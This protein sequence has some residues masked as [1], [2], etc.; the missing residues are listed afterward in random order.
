MSGRNEDYF[1]DSEEKLLYLIGYLLIAKG[2]VGFTKENALDSYNKRFKN[3]DNS[4]DNLLDKFI[5]KSII[6]KSD[7]NYFLTPAGE[8]QAIAFLVKYYD[9]SYSNILATADAS[10]AY[11]KISSEIQGQYLGQ[12]DMTDKNQLDKLFS[13]VNVAESDSILDFGCGLGYITEFLQKKTG[14][15]CV[16]LDIAS[17][18]L[19]LAR[20]RNIGNDKLEYIHGDMNNPDFPPSS[21]NVIIVIDTLYFVRDLYKTL[22]NLKTLL[23]PGGKILIFYTMK[24]IGNRS[25]PIF[26]PDGTKLAQELHKLDL[27]YDYY[28]YT[29]NE[30]RIWELSKQIMEAEKENFLKENN[31][32][33]FNSRMDEIQM[34]LDTKDKAPSTRYLYDIRI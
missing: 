3:L 14:A 29:E 12:F 11:R 31:E 30:M 20:N 15:H 13:L 5:R 32:E 33:L 26:S 9:F 7:N 17:G 4:M 27:A 16:G 25:D 2:N 6:T 19:N 21:F 22:E 24:R 23:K 10:E 18:A 1:K 34:M 28:D 8:D